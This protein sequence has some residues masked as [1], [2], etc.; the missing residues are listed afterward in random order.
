MVE[1]TSTSTTHTRV[2][3]SRVRELRRG[4]GGCLPARRVARSVGVD[5]RVAGRAPTESVVVRPGRLGR[6][7]VALLQSLLPELVL[8]GA[9]LHLPLHLL[10]SPLVLAHLVGLVRLPL[11]TSALL[12]GWC[13]GGGHV[14]VLLCLANILQRKLFRVQAVPYECVESLQVVV[15]D[16]QVE[17][18]IRGD[19]SGQQNPPG[20][21]KEFLD[22]SGL[23]PVHQ[24]LGGRGQVQGGDDVVR[25]GQLS[26]HLLPGDCLHLVNNQLPLPPSGLLPVHQPLGG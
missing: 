24:P 5:G 2:T 15:V 10:L 4:A 17:I 7:E 6:E 18:V 26:L 12:P 21:D 3:S 13:S 23:L 22:S 1:R 8:P 9:L 19:V 20:K 11:P 16:D 14:V 25:V